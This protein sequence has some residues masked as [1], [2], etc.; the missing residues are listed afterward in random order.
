MRAPSVAVLSALAAS[1]TTLASNVF[2]K[3][4]CP[5]SYW[6]T[7]TRGNQQTNGPFEL[8]SAEGYTEAIIGVG[9]TLGVTD[10]SRYWSGSTSKLVFGYSSSNATVYW[11]VMSVDGNPFASDAGKEFNITSTK[12]CGGEET[13]T[14]PVYAC[15]D[16]GVDL[17]L[18]L[19]SQNQ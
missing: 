6:L 1:M 18:T 10:N 15:R 12:G 13:T 19:C 11:S 8:H 5:P 3:N 4:F 7:I 17:T 9:N 2:V 16:D 14:G